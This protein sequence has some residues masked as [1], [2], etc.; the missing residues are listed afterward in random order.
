MRKR[1]VKKLLNYCS[2]KQLSKVS[3]LQF[4]LPLLG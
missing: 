4:G 1:I 3:N 2:F